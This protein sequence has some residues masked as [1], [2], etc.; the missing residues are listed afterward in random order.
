M[1]AAERVKKARRR[2]AR[3]HI[4]KLFA[5]QPK[6]SPGCSLAPLAN[7]DA[8][9]CLRPSS[10]TNVSRNAVEAPQA[11]HT[12]PL[13]WVSVPGLPATVFSLSVLDTGSPRR[14]QSWPR[15][16]VYEPGQGVKP[17]IRL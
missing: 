12:A 8:D 3:H 1:L 2:I 14:W 11:T 7:S 5:H 9:T 6:C 10:F 13:A 15:K 4:T 16:L 17:R